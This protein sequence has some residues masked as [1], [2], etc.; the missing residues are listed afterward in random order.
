MRTDTGG[1]FGTT[2][3]RCSSVGANSFAK[4]S[5]AATLNVDGRPSCP[6]SLC[7]MGRAAL[8]ELAIPISSARMG[9]APLHP[10]YGGLNRRVRCAHRYRDRLRPH[11]GRSYNP[12]QPNTSQALRVLASASSS[13]VTP[14]ISASAAQISGRNSGLLRP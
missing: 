4:G 5:A 2:S 11:K 13:G 14:R 6:V 9:I 12:A 7:R 10:S 8:R 3:N 1:G